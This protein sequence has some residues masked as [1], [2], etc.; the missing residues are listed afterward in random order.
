M[1]IEQLRNEIDNID[2]QLVSL[3]NLRYSYCN[4]IGK[5]KKEQG[6]AVLDSNR[7]QE[8]I[9]K[10]S[11]EEKYDGMVEALWPIIMSFSKSLQSI[12]D[13]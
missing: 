6:I 5:I 8:I 7:E 1:R 13:K 3:L 10:L 4:E 11:K 2:L 12:L 9:D